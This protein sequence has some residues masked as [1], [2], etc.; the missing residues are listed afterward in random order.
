MAFLDF[1]L[2]LF[3]SNVTTNIK[4]VAIGKNN[5]AGDTTIY[6]TALSNKNISDVRKL[7]VTDEGSSLKVRAYFVDGE[8]DENFVGYW[9]GWQVAPNSKKGVIWTSLGKANII[10]KPT[11]FTEISVWV[12]PQN[13]DKNVERNIHATI[14]SK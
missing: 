3:G 9:Y 2:K 8:I 12:F 1:L 11:N 13:D 14:T 4:N 6:N 10:R 7:D 5:A